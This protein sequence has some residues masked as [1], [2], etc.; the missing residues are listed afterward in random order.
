MRLFSKRTVIALC[1]ATAL[2]ALTATPGLAGVITPTDQTAVSTE[3]PIDSVHYRYGW[4]HH[5]HWHHHWRTTWSGPYYYYAYPYGYPY[6]SAGGGSG[7]L[8]LGLLG[9]L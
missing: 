1:C 6:G 3:S 2:G 4:C 5:H 7:L 8:G 9:I